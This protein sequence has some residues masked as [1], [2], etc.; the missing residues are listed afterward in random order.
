LIAVH[1]HQ[2]TPELRQQSQQ[3]FKV[4]TPPVERPRAAAKA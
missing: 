1:K 3:H 2:D 4:G